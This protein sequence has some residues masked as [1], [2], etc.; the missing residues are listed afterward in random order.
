[1]NPQE[2]IYTGKRRFIRYY[3]ANENSGYLIPDT[4]AAKQRALNNGAKYFSTFSSCRISQPGILIPRKWGDLHLQICLSHKSFDYFPT[5][6]NWLHSLLTKELLIGELE[7]ISIG[8]NGLGIWEIVVPDYILGFDQGHPLLA[9]AYDYVAQLAEQSLHKHVVAGSTSKSLR[10][11]EVHQANKRMPFSTFMQASLDDCESWECNK[12]RS[13]SQRALTTLSHRSTRLFFLKGGK[14]IWIQKVSQKIGAKCEFLNRIASCYPVMEDIKLLMGISS[15]PEAVRQFFLTSAIKNNGGSLGA[16]IPTN[17]T[18][19]TC[20]TIRELGRCKKKQC[21]LNSPG[22]LLVKWP[23]VIPFSR[24]PN[25]IDTEV[26]KCAI[27]VFQKLEKREV[28]EFQAR[29]AHRLVRGSFKTISIVEEG[30]ALLEGRGF[31]VRPDMPDYS[32]A[33]RRPSPW[34]LVNPSG[35]KQLFYP[36]SV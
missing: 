32:H 27:A 17:D 36:I 28:F 15:L 30:L 26:L 24:I 35:H 3:G 12:S 4:P 5:F 34:Y 29:D 22:E 10:L 16:P 2:K 18:V 13:N 19:V 23:Q 11:Y 8:F 9:E 25:G 7:S 14:K 6:K 21:T 1:M 20:N 33:G 31:V